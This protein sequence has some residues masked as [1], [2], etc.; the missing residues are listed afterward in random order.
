MLACAHQ[1]GRLTEYSVKKEEASSSLGA[2]YEA[3]ACVQFRDGLCRWSLAPWAGGGTAG[4]QVS[5]S[6][7]DMFQTD[8][9]LVAPNSADAVI[10]LKHATP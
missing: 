2:L 1:Q 3:P 6:G 8:R 9:S 7:C 10:S 5:H 4:E